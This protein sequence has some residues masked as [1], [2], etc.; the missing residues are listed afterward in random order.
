MQNDLFSLQSTTITLAYLSVHFSF[1]T[2]PSYPKC[3]LCKKRISNVV[4]YELLEGRWE[5]VKEKWNG[6]SPTVCQECAGG[7]ILAQDRIFGCL[8]PGDNKKYWATVGENSYKEQFIREGIVTIPSAELL[9]EFRFTDAVLKVVKKRG[10]KDRNKLQFLAD[11]VDERS[12]KKSQHTCRRWKSI[13]GDS[14]SVVK[15]DKE[16]GF[17]YEQSIHLCVQLERLLFP[18]IF[19][20]R[21]MMNA[22]GHPSEHLKRPCSSLQCNKIN[23]LAR[24]AGLTTTQHLHRD[25]DVFGLSVIYVVECNDSYEFVY[26]EGSHELS[27][28]PDVEKFQDTNIAKADVKRIQVKKGHFI[29]FSGNLVHAGGRSSASLG[30]NKTL[31]DSELS[32]LSLQFDFSHDGL[33]KG[34]TRSN[35]ET[36][37]WKFEP[38]EDDPND[39]INYSNVFRYNGESQKFRAA[40]ANATTDWI[41]DSRGA[42]RKSKRLR[43]R[44]EP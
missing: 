41:L 33:S 15:P 2:M 37:V 34:A 32:D 17:L 25:C 27:Y 43:S 38:H 24:F 4:L 1:I 42:G 3:M 8:Y 10:L 7:K 12:M 9:G 35:G 13:W 5:S 18:E 14:E 44:K 11:K 22:A 19:H 40:V 39:P 28:E 20:G 26:A 36:L 30:P 21:G 29:C 6:V 16:W 31:T 23:L